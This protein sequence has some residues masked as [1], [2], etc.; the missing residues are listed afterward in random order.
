MDRRGLGTNSIGTTSSR[1]RPQRT[2]GSRVVPRAAVRST[3][4]TAC[5]QLRS[6][7]P[8]PLL[9]TAPLRHAVLLIDGLP[10]LRGIRLRLGPPSVP[11]GTIC[12]RMAHGDA[13]PGSASARVSACQ[14][15]Q[16]AL[17]QVATGLRH[18][19]RP[20]PAIGDPEDR[21]RPTE[22]LEPSPL[23]H[24]SSH[25]QLVAAD[26][27]PIPWRSPPA[28]LFRPQPHDRDHPSTTHRGGSPRQV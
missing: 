2:R 12:G 27:W 11:Q 20:R 23:F 16:H 8:G 3:R 4:I 5:E 18:P 26:A 1:R 7:G 17:A 14:T 19:G 9:E 25:R 24:G 6:C 21:S 13:T 22:Q 10:H 15:D 28:R